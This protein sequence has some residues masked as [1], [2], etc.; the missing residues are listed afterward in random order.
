MISTHAD[1][2]VVRKKNGRGALHIALAFMITLCFFTALLPMTQN[3]SAQTYPTIYLTVHRVQ[4]IDAIDLFGGDWDW[5]YYVGVLDG[6]WTWTFYE[7]P[8]GQDV[9]IDELIEFDV[10]SPDLTFSMVFCEGDF[11]TNDDRADISSDLFRGDDDVANC[12][13][14]QEPPHGAFVATWNL[15]TETLSGNTTVEEL[16]YIKTSGDFDGSTSTDE[17]DANVWFTISDNYAPP[18]ADAGPPK[19]GY[20]GESISLDGSGSTASAG[21]SID[22][23]EWDYNDDGS[24]DDFGMIVSTTFSTHGIHTVKLTVT[25]SIGVQSTDTTTVE[26]LNK[27]PVA[28]FTYAPDNPS[29]ADNIS[30]IDTSTDPD[31]T[32]SS[33]SWDFG[34]GGDSTEKNPTH[35]FVDDGNYDVEL[36]VTDNAGGQDTESKTVVVSNVGPVASFNCV[37]VEPT[38]D[39]TVEFTDSSTDSD[40][41]IASW[42][43]DFGDDYTSTVQNPTHRYEKSGEYT[44]QLTVTDDDGDT[45]TVSLVINVEEPLV[46]D[47]LLLI[48]LMIIVILIIA[49][50]AW[51]LLRR[52]RKESDEVPSEVVDEEVQPEQDY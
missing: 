51:L 48:L 4:E 36:T 41:T 6:T 49:I 11:W 50:L 7:A 46:S 45:D 28:A 17:N 43:W 47:D 26:I 27:D 24:P 32:I 10:T 20:V 16:G 52:R 23:Y 14:S 1:W 13:P 31:G 2:R 33:W 21:S 44:I 5:Y 38:T 12:V 25:D 35:R 15:V 29:T 42:S 9:I 34:D 40:G 8:N 37:P 39:E 30:F 3:A 19:T 18:V 22:T